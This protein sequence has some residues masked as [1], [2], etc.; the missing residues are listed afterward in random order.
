M[1]MVT[2]VLALLSGGLVG[3]SLGMIGGGGSILATPLLIYVVG[4]KDPHLAIGTSALAV[5]GNAALNLIGHAKK[6]NVRWR[7]AVIFAVAG[8]IGA[9]IGSTLGKNFP[10]GQ[11]LSLFAL[12]MIFVALR[13][14]REGK[15]KLPPPRLSDSTMT[16]V[17]LGFIV[18]II[19]GFF[20]IGGG[21]L[22]VPGLMAATAMP[23]INAIGSSLAAVTSFGLTTA[24]NYAFSG[25]VAWDIALEFIVGGLVGGMFGR[26]LATRLSVRHGV[27]HTL[28][29]VIVICVALYMLLQQWLAL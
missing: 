23:I 20:G 25:L 28:F 10:G 14:L 3:F 6:G 8:I 5:A 21:F 1:D 7:P 29:A 12:L 16:T 26:K 27:L 18:G 17:A 24:A 15:K 11:L 22:I 4:L 2:L 13:M 19:S 9:L